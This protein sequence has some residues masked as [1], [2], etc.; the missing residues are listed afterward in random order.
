MAGL[1]GWQGHGSLSMFLTRGWHCSHLDKCC[2]GKPLR[3]V[4][5]AMNSSTLPYP[6]PPQSITALAHLRA[7]VLYVIDISEQC[8]YTIQQQVR[9]LPR[10][11]MMALRMGAV[12]QRAQSC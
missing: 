7:A 6:P 11:C 8:G 4:R 5:V 12:H 2:C 3:V 9:G 1:I 10:H